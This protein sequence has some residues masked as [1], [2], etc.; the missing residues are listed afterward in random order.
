LVAVSQKSA[1]LTRANQ[2]GLIP[3][4]VAAVSLP[5]NEAHVLGMG[6]ISSG[7]EQL[8]ETSIVL[9]YGTRPHNML[10]VIPSNVEAGVTVKWQTASFGNNSI[11]AADYPLFTEAQIL[12]ARDRQ[13]QGSA[14]GFGL[15]FGLLV[16]APGRVRYGLILKDLFASINW[17]NGEEKYGEGIP[18]TVVLAAA[19]T[20][21]SD[22][23][24]TTDFRSQLS[25]GPS[26]LRLG[27]E[28]K[29][30][31]RIMLRGGI[32]QTM[33]AEQNRDYALGLGVKQS[34]GASLAVQ[35]DYAYQI[36]SIANTQRFSFIIKF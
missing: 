36:H 1:L 4:N 29:L 13:V 8:K 32:G 18:G 11:S 19:Y 35:V 31:D 17:D 16:S 10:S 9:S 5:I 34:F 3:Y 27:A 30:W 12:E 25:G 26:H 22:L 23:M 33:E 2:F 14:T 24:F 21:M 6:V 7:D 28:K 20:T 15:D